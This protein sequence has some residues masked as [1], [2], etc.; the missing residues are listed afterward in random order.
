M[1]RVRKYPI[2]VTA[3]VSEETA[4]R[5]RELSEEVGV[6][7][8]TLVRELLEGVLRA[9]VRVREQDGFAILHLDLPVL[10]IERD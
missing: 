1:P 10:V 6:K 3:K 8:S 9:I 7:P 5:I 4:K 2:T